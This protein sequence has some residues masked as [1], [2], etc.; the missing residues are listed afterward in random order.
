[1][2]N[3]SA[4]ALG[5]GVGSADDID[6]GMMLGLSHPRGPFAWMEQ[7]GAGPC[8]RHARS[9]ERGLS[10]GALPPRPGFAPLRKRSRL[11]IRTEHYLRSRFP[12]LPPFAR[13]FSQ[14]LLPPDALATAGSI[15]RRPLSDRSRGR[16]R[17]GP[18][19]LSQIPDRHPLGRGHLGRVAQ[20]PLGVEGGL[21]SRA[22]RGD[23]LAVGVIDKVAGREHSGRL[24]RVERP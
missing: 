8:A 11:T 19:R 14:S 4:F 6:K 12:P 9:A 2:I 23:R 10:R 15:L 3:E 20:V 24:V 5:E 18:L 16:G 13:P 17:R 7:I 1:M 22:G 21:T